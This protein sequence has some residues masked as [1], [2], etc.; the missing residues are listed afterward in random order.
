MKIFFKTT[1]A[2]AGMVSVAVLLFT[3][4]PASAQLSIP[5]GAQILIKSYPDFIKGYE[6]GYLLQGGASLKKFADGFCQALEHLW[7]VILSRPLSV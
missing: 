1:A 2:L 4:V 7:L 3:A 5:Q 6:N